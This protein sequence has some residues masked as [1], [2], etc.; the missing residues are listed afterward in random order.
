MKVVSINTSDIQGGAARAA[1]RLHRSLLASNV[2]S[3]IIVQSKNSDDFTV[4]GPETFSQKLASKLRPSIDSLPVRLYKSRSKTLFSAAWIPSSKIVK[5]INDLKPDIVHLHWINAGFLRI[6][7]IAE[8]K[9][10]ILW[11]LHDMWAF[12]GGCH[13]DEGCNR[14]IETCGKCKV[15][16]SGNKF[17]LSSRGYSRKHKSGSKS[18]V[19]FVALSQW[20]FDEANKSSLLKNKV[21]HQL[22]NPIDTT[23]FSPFDR[24][25]SRKLLNLPMDKK[26]ILFGAISSTSD[27]RKGFKEL[28]ESLEQ[29]TTDNTELVVFGAT[30]PKNG[31]D[32]IINTHFLGHLHDDLSLRVLYSAVDVMVVPSLQENLSN[33][34]MESLACGTPVVSFG[35]GGNPDMIEHM[36]NGYLAKPYDINDLAYGISWILNHSEP[37]SLKEAAR[38]K[39]L[40]K[41]DSLIVAEQYISVYRNLLTK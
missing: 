1:Y 2:D 3:H 15:L 38:K 6:E 7:D 31:S 21:I 36:L 9:A 39:V 18:D 30:K 32:F 29:L 11:S 13:Y 5:K 12:T 28:I 40:D 14:F 20:M 34:I 41:F 27:P 8:I 35:I 26:L 19:E 25:Q 24:V 33:A 17:D 10:P 16:G 23:I 4:T 22:P 37:S